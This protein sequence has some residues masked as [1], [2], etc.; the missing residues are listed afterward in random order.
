MAKQVRQ[1]MRTLQTLRGDGKVFANGK[2]LA[3]A[4]LVVA[5]RRL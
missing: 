3:V 5:D 1:A 4:D 2:F